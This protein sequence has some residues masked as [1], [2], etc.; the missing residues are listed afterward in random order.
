MMWNDYL[1]VLK[2]GNK[3]IL[4]NRYNGKWIKISKECYDILELAVEKGYTDEKLF[5]MFEEQEDKIYFQKLLKVLYESEFLVI[6]QKRVSS[7][8]VDI[9]ITSRCNLCCTHCCV[10]ADTLRKTDSLTT[11][12]V[13]AIMRKVVECTPRSICLTGGEPLVREDFEE[14]LKYLQNI[15]SGEIRLM[16]NATLI[17]EYKAKMLSEIVSAIDISLDGIDEATCSKIRGK[18]VFKKVLNA[19][20]LLHHNG[21]SNI[22]LSMVLTKEN[23]PL[24]DQFSELN[25]K[26]GTR[27]VVRAFSPI[28]RGLKNATQLAPGEQEKRIEEK[29]QLSNL[30]EDYH[31]CCCGATSKEMYINYKGD[32]FPC[33]LLEREKYVLG[34]M[35][36]VSDFREF[37]YEKKYVDTEGYKNLQLLQPENHEFCKDCSVN[38]FCW[39]CLHYLDLL[40]GNTSYFEKE[41]HEI[42]KHLEKVIWEEE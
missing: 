15:Y 5:G 24:K 23:Y 6:E 3:I 20:E 32:I 39:N 26:L 8:D 28:G 37:V 38:L 11:E 40:E 27:A 33:G 31:I 7:M 16:T 4:G 13:K 25:E 42:Q 29:I 10:D 21:F 12:E 2:K 36:Q 22:S 17:D 41:C 18:G 1:R 19:I 14:L 9:A 35:R 34:N 30:A